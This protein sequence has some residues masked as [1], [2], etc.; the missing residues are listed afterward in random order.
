[1][2]RA[3]ALD[4]LAKAEGHVIDDELRIDRLRN[5]AASPSSLQLSLENPKLRAA[6]APYF[7]AL[8]SAG[9]STDDIVGYV[10]AINGKIAG[11]DVYGHVTE[12][13]RATSCRRRGPS[14]GHLGAGAR[15]D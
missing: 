4:L 1:M 8:R 2:D 3:T 13:W 14:G 7:D 12:S 9:E 6:R 15:N 5:A 10:F 11:G